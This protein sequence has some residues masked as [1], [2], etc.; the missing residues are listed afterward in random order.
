MIYAVKF[1]F[2]SLLCEEEKSAQGQLVTQKVFQGQYSL[3]PT[4]NK[5]IDGDGSVPNLSLLIN[6]VAKCV[7]QM[8][9]EL[10]I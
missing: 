3:T 1:L 9:F 4:T 7:A 2:G 8:S 5:V 10:S 6:L